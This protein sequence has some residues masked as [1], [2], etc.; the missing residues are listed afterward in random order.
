MATF[1]TVIDDARV[2]LN[3]EVSELNPDPRYTEAQLMGYAR[4]AL[5]EARRV[6][7]DLFL[8]NL[9]TSFA[10]YTAASTIPIS[11]DYLISLVDYVAHRAEL[12]DD[13]FTVDGRSSILLQKFK[14]ALLGI[15]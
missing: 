4:S 15:S 14:A 12:R 9:T 10:S 5:I 13:E 1:Q 3:D 6:R 11:D 8:S 7:P 2:L